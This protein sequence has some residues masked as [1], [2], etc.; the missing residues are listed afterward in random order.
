MFFLALL[1]CDL[2][3]PPSP[4][5]SAAFWVSFWSTDIQLKRVGLICG[6][7]APMGLITLYV[8]IFQQLR[9]IEDNEALACTQF[10]AGVLALV[11]GI[12]IPFLVWSPLV[13]RPDTLEPHLTQTL[14]DLG[15]FSFF[16]PWP[17]IIQ[18][19]AFAFAVFRDHE[20]KVFPRWFGYLNLWVALIAIP[21]GTL[22]FFKNGPMAWNGLLPWWVAL[23]GAGVWGVP[24]FILLFRAIGQQLGQEAAGPAEGVET[25]GAAIDRST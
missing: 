11:P 17:A 21:G 12:I 19:V 5:N 10:G 18:M 20:Q 23:V 4:G 6:L 15:M 14:T 25:R 2:F 22:Y 7:L 3:P 1:L 16:V 24:V 8:V 13:Y 9:R